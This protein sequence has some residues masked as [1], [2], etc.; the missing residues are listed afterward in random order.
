MIS[1]SYQ[2]LKSREGICLVFVLGVTAIVT[3]PHEGD[4]C[5]AD[6]SG[7]VKQPVVINL[8]SGREGEPP[9]SMLSRSSLY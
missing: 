8:I 3:W 2:Y 7:A 9:V 5:S 6:K 4:I 1:F